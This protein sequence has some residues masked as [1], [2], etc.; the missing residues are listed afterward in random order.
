MILICISSIFICRVCHV[1]FLFRK[2]GGAGGDVADMKVERSVMTDSW[3]S[4]LTQWFVVTV[5]CW[6]Y[7]FMA[8]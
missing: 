5:L 8:G 4:V 3:L 1:I 7:D 6:N 2:P